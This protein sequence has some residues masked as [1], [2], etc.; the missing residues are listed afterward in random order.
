MVSYFITFLYAVMANV[1]SDYIAKWTD[2][3]K[4]PGI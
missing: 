1:I 3:K 4:Y 2:G